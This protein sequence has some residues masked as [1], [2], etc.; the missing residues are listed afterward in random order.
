MILELHSSLTSLILAH[1]YDTAFCHDQQ[2]GSIEPT[3]HVRYSWTGPCSIVVLN[4]T[5]ILLHWS[6]QYSSIEPTQHVRYS[7]TELT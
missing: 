7:W 4:Q 6:M 3:Q 5:N 1:V 2:Y